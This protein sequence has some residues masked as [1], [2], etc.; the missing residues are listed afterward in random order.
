VAAFV[1]GGGN[2]AGDCWVDRAQNR[3]RGSNVRLGQKGIDCFQRWVKR[4]TEIVERLR[5]D[6][7]I[8]PGA[9]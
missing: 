9:R 1:T 7:D 2:V 6:L 4:E 8:D 3:K 5:H